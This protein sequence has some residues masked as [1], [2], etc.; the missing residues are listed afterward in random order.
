MAI[1]AGEVELTARVVADGSPSGDD[2]GR[3]DR[4]AATEGIS[5]NG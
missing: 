2:I 5:E 4:A 1:I 3:D